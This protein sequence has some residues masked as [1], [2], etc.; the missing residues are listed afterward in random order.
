VHNIKN[1]M[2][3]I[4]TG[5]I[6]LMS[7]SSFGQN[8]SSENW[9][10]NELAQYS[11]LIE[12]GNYVHNKKKS[13]IS[14]D[15]L[16]KRYIYFDNV[17]NDV[18]SERKENRIQSFDTLFYFF[19]NTVDS[20]GF[21][22]LDAKPVRFYKNHKIYEPFKKEIA[23]ET[24]GGEK[25]Y[26]KDTNV[27]AYYRKEEPEN[28]LGTLLFEPETDKLCAWIMIDQGG[29]KYFLTFNLL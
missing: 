22:N 9:T 11:K 23:K 29:Y 19:R 27:F 12:L 13:E 14:K 6:L 1:V 17:L 26:T 7:I 4:I 25:M 21:K 10:K 3:N 20:I 24:V 5:I 15:T 28:P 16:F 18:D 2:K 8:A